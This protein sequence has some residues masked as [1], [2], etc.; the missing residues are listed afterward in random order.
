MTSHLR[1]VPLELSEAN[2]LVKELHRHH[3]PVVGHRFSIGVINAKTM[4]TRRATMAYRTSPAN[5]PE[6]APN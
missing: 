4:T 2:A 3:F 1:I 5:N 6:V